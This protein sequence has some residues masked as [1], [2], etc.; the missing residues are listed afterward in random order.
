[1]TVAE[2]RRRWSLARSSV[3]LRTTVVATLVVALAMGVGAI[4]LVGLLRD[5]LRD[6]VEDAVDQRL[7][8]TVDALES[9][10][11]PASVVGDDDDRFVRVLGPDGRVV[12]SSGDDDAPRVGPDV[13][14][15]TTAESSEGERFLVSSD[16][17]SVDGQQLTVI[18]GESME[19]VDES[20]STATRL[21]VVGVP[22]LV[23][24]VGV[25]TWFVV[26]RAF[27]PVDRITREVDDITG[28]DLD[29]RV[30]APPSRDEIGRLARTMNRMLVRLEAAQR[31]QREFVSDASHELRSPTAALRQ[32]AEVTL[33]YPGQVTADELAETVLAESVRL[34]R[35]VDALLL[36][37]RI[38]ERS[39]AVEAR[40][41]DLD[42]LVLAEARRVRDADGID[43]DTS[44]V[45]AA[46]VRGD[47]ALLAQVIRNLVDNA[48]RHADSRVALGVRED[49]D[50]VLLSVEDD[51][52]GIAPDQRERV[53]DRFV[54]LDEARA[55]D[56]GGS[57]LG[58]AIVRALTELHG[59]TVLAVEGRLGGAR[60]EVRLPS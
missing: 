37:A 57:G 9:G 28:A 56:D 25:A 11:A 3:R 39:Q 53:F 1:M 35:I 59:G 22:I 44:A 29:R 21:L 32:H 30:S 16:D 49:G 46:R 12:A 6:S 38:D 8:T 17:A 20:G 47:G 36:L 15:S 41:V 52:R 45:T 42:D 10:Q 34:Q 55:R 18:V 54:R 14:D 24:L 23:V 5:S 50:G 19:D 48:T 40:A 4:A 7:E 60:F 2:R 43:V 31:R 33:A 51:G 58:L 27:R 26:G 13:D